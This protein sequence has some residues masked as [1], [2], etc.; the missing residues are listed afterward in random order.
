MELLSIFLAKKIKNYFAKQK[1]R[2]MVPSP[3]PCG[4][5]PVSSFLTIA[6]GFLGGFLYDNLFVTLTKNMNDQ[7]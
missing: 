5:G 7:E 2:V 4:V 1:V 6:Y 3:L